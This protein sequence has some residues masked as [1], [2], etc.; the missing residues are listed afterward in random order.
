MS[1]WPM[2]ACASARPGARQLPE[3]PGDPDGGQRHRGGRDPSRLRFP[4]GECRVRRDGGGAWADLHRPVGRAYPHDGRQDHRQGGDGLARRAPGARQRGRG[5]RSG[6]GRDR[7]GGDRLP[8]ADQ[9][10]GGRRRARHEGGAQRGRARARPGASPAPRPAP[11]SATTPSISR[12]TST[13]R[14]ISSCRCWPT[15]MAAW[16]IWASAIAACSGGTRSCWRRPG[17]P[18]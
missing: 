15:P 1:A 8:G 5:D 11:R 7:R 17:H 18:R 12:N 6:A 14:A 9:G 10:G 3:H 13:G 2:R 4:V 16:S